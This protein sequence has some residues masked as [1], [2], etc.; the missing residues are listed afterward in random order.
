MWSEGLSAT[1]PTPV[2]MSF[3]LR[4][5]ASSLLFAI[6]DGTH[7]PMAAMDTDEGDDWA[8]FFAWRDGQRDAG[9]RLAARYLGLLTRFFLN[10]VRDP[11]TAADLVSE[12]FL[13]C[14]AARD[15]ATASGSFRSYLFAIALNKLR[16]YFRKQAKARRELD[17]FEDVCVANALPHSQMS[18]ISHA[19]E[20]KLLVRALRRLSLDQQIVLELNFFEDLTGPEIAELLGLPPATVYTRI[21]RGR[22][23]LSTLVS[24]LADNP[25]LAESTLIGID[26]WARMI[27]AE[28][29][30]G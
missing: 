29:D 25:E 1:S 18:M 23:K 9:E 17:D 19:Q 3:T 26:T 8:L 7:Q 24:E 21:R 28:L 5:I 16:G 12:T 11:D 6:F 14:T 22:D 20:G 30:K 2:W 4:R 15:R 27:R 13:G 10:K